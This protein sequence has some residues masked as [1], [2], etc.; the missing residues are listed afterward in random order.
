MTRWWALPAV[1][2]VLL[3]AGCAPAVTTPATSDAEIAATSSASAPAPAPSPVAPAV[4]QRPDPTPTISRRP[5]EPPPACTAAQLGELSEQSRNFGL[6]EDGE[7]RLF[8]SDFTISNVSSTT[9]YLSGWMGVEFRGDTTVVTCQGPP[10]GMPSAS[11][12]PADCGDIVSRTA[13]VG[14]PVERL[15]DRSEAV[16]LAPG[17][18]TRFSMLSEGIQCPVHPYQAL[19]TVPGD[20]KRLVLVE[21]GLCARGP[22][23]ITA[24]GHIVR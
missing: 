22:I 24:I 1:A 17:A 12:S 16:V 6:S 2:S 3:A 23:S 19:F 14:D 13:L 18:E 5:A 20:R 8:A 11:P 4:T 7:N 10:A 9:C 15:G 21:P